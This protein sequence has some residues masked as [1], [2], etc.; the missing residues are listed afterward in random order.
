MVQPTLNDTLAEERTLLAAERT[1]S[2]W[3]RTGLSAIA[4][5]LAIV[6]LVSFQSTAHQFIARLVGPILVLWGAGIFAFAFLSF[7][8]IS[9][10][11]EYK[12]VASLSPLSLGLITLVLILIAALILLLTL[13]L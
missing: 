13:Q 1:Y 4:G 11:L 5:G 2:A 10:S 7:R 6:K 8:R 12:G 9:R 3:V